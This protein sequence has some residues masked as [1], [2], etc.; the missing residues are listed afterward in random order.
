[1]A[2][3][4]PNNLQSTFGY[5][6]DNLEER[7]NKMIKKS[8]PVVSFFPSVP[9]FQQGLDLFS[10]RPAWKEYE[11]LLN[12][13]DFT[14]PNTGN[15][16]IRLAFLA[17]NFPTDSFTNEYGEN[18]LQKF[19]DVASEG[20]ASLAQIMG[21]SS[22]SDAW[23]TMQQNFASGEGPITKG[24]G[25][26]MEWMGNIGS[27]TLGALKNTPIVGGQVGKTTNIVDRLLAGSRIDFPMVW[28]SSG[29]QPSYSFTV[30]L[31]NPF[32]Q[33][34]DY[35]NKY[36]VGP[37]A[38][39]ML[40][41]VPRAQDS[42]TFTWPFLHRIECPGIFEL[43]PGYISNI[44]VVKGGDQQQISLNQ[45]LGIVDVR[46]DVGSLYS[47]MLAGSNKVTSRRPTVLKY[48]R[49]MAGQKHISSRRDDNLN[50][51]RQAGDGPQGGRS[52]IAASRED[53]IRLQ[54]RKYTPPTPSGT[55]V[56]SYD[57]RRG[58]SPKIQA[59]A[60][61]PDETPKDRVDEEDVDV[62][63]SL[64]DQLPF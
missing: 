41:G 63:N 25:K 30:R 42:S 13:N 60:D 23:N 55:Q 37:I 58:V 24:M 47:S 46:I 15:H 51:T 26:G 21:A 39:I 62:Y 3:S 52:V 11:T 22:A 61:E 8:M 29:F 59:E 35:T 57:V 5:P 4:R 2:L 49:A 45:R 19:T 54:G 34:D 64:A 10:L 44:T 48:A 17:D 50:F 36:I 56:L 18:F 28:K 20:A 27:A 12:D 33:D 38:A 1:M 9:Q 7:T 31:Y 14:T 16:G 32:P 43:D 53:A 40:M 6:P